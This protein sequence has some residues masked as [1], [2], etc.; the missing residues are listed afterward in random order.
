MGPC[1]EKVEHLIVEAVEA[2]PDV[3]CQ[4][5]VPPAAKP[6]RSVGELLRKGTVEGLQLLRGVPEGQVQAPATVRCA[7]RLV[8]GPTGFEPGRLARP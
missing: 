8:G 2:T 7:D 5:M 4:Q 3:P 1:P 6:D